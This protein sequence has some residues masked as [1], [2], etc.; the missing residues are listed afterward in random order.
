[1]RAVL[2][3]QLTN[4]PQYPEV[5]GDGKILRFLRGHDMD[6]EKASA[7]M[8]KFLTWRKENG[9]DTIRDN[10]VNGGMS[11]PNLFPKGSS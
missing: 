7:M 1:M 3:E 5:V 4:R 8:S 10:I 11:R 2:G 6:V 9:I